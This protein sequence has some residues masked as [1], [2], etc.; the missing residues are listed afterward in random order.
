MGKSEGGRSGQ[1]K[2]YTEPKVIATS[3]FLSL[4]IGTQL[5]VLTF[6]VYTHAG[7]YSLNI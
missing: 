5:L 2:T 4:L 7:I 3:Y 6:N 1:E